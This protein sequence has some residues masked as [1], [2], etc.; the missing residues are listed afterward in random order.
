M[1]VIQK[2]KVGEIA[3]D[4]ALCNSLCWIQWANILISFSR[5]CLN[6]FGSSD[7]AP[8]KSKQCDPSK[9]KYIKGKEKV[10]MES[11]IINK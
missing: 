4:I 11:I 9:K 3:S 2:K 7:F 8:S 5:W 6:H 1:I 10:S